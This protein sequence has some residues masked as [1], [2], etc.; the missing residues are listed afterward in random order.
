M[1]KISTGL[2][3]SGTLLAPKEPIVSKVSSSSQLFQLLG[4]SGWMDVSHAHVPAGSSML[5]FKIFTNS[6]SSKVPSF[7]LVNP[8]NVLTD[9]SGS[10]LCSNLPIPCRSTGMDTVSGST[11][12]II[13]A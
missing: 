2:R 9:G 11:P 5:S 10:M 3:I 7:V 4:T 13:L 6:A 12:G 1:P 8:P